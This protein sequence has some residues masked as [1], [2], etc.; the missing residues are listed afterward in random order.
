MGRNI[1]SSRIM[2]DEKACDLFFVKPSKGYDLHESISGL[3]EFDGVQEVMLTSGEYGFV[4]RARCSEKK[5]RSISR[6]ISGR[7]GKC[8]RLVSHVR[9][10][11]R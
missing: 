7:M 1:G 11:K 3:M 8:S 5:G 9:Y 2:V 4:I 10:R 6:Y